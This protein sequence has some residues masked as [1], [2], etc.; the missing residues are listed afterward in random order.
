M[1][2]SGVTAT[3]KG[4]AFGKNA[5]EVQDW[6]ALNLG[7]NAQPRPVNE[8][9]RLPEVMPDAPEKQKQRVLL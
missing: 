1:Q 7:G 9:K 2:K 3:A 4:R 8:S 5:D 6:V